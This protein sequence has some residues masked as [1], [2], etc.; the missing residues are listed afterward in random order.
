MELCKIFTRSLDSLF[1]EDMGEYTVLST[2]P[3]GIQSIENYSLP[4]KM[5]MP[6]GMIGWDFPELSPEQINVE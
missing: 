1:R 6:P 4:K 3:E 2:N 5:A